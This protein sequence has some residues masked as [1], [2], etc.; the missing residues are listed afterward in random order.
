M[1]EIQTGRNHSAGV[2]KEKVEL[3][4]KGGVV[5]SRY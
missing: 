2:A 1:G 5:P 3:T 4:N